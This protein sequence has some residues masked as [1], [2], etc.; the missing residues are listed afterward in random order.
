MT[1]S[2][3][4]PI[5]YYILNN[6]VYLPMVNTGNITITYTPY[7]KVLSN[8]TLQLSINTNYETQVYMASNVLPT[9]IPS[10]IQGFQ[11]TGN[12]VI[13]TLAPGNY[14]IN[15]LTTGPVITMK[16]TTTQHT[17][18]TNMAQL[19]P[20]SSLGYIIVIVVV[21]IL[22]SVLLIIRRRK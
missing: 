1:N 14:V 6:E 17:A 15:F 10:N 9:T 4:Q 20:Y 7:I 12:G 2:T 19:I 13:L 18:K 8:G 22:L 21:V 16:T 3:G 5:P 11:E